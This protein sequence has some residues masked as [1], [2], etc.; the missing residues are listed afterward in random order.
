MPGVPLYG[1]RGVLLVPA[2]SSSERLSGEVIFHFLCSFCGTVSHLP[3]PLYIVPAPCSERKQRPLH[4]LPTHFLSP[5]HGNV[6]HVSPQ[7]PCSLIT[8]FNL[9]LQNTF[10]LMAGKHWR[11][12][13]RSRPRHQLVSSSWARTDPGGRGSGLWSLDNY[14]RTS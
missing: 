5:P 7:Q 4:L 6:S 13:Q 3:Q 2:A 12:C 9:G 14:L 10:F 11:K 8:A 1:L